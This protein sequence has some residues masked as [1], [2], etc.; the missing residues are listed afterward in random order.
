MDENELGRLLRRY[1]DELAAEE[2]R[3]TVRPELSDALHAYAG[4][5]DRPRPS[6]LR[7]TLVGAALS[8]CAAAVWFALIPRLTSPAGIH[9][10]HFG[11]SVAASAEGGGAGIELAL[12]DPAPVRT[13]VVLAPSERCIVPLAE[14]QPGLARDNGGERRTYHI[15]CPAAAAQASETSPDNLFVMLVSSSGAAPSAAELSSAIPDDL[16]PAGAIESDP[17][18]FRRRIGRVAQDLESRFH[19]EVHVRWIGTSQAIEG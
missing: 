18:E 12:S 3:A 8:A 19:C 9:A 11:A 1:G 14:A 13:V 4:R 6:T 7:L 16:V 5:A 17:I 10:G 15:E 2:L